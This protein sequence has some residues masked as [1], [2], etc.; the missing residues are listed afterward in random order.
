MPF[1]HIKGRFQM[2]TYGFVFLLYAFVASTLVHDNS[3]YADANYEYQSL[4]DLPD[5][6][7]IDYMGEGK[8]QISE[9]EMDS[10]TLNKMPSDFWDTDPQQAALSL[11]DLNR[12]ANHK[13]T[14]HLEINEEKE[15]P[16]DLCSVI[17][18]FAPDPFHHA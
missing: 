7:I 10:T 11:L 18:R 16:P 14:F 5:Q 9:F 3:I 6:A 17:Y 15:F 2:K 13:E 4:S 1:K 8:R 12:S